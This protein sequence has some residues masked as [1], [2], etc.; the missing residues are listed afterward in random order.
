MRD[1]NRCHDVESQG[2]GI[3]QSRDLLQSY[4]C[5]RPKTEFLGDLGTNLLEIGKSGND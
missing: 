4:S 3:R 2:D 1:S 5:D